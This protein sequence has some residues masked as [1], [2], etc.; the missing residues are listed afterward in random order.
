[1]ALTFSSVRLAI[2]PTSVPCPPAGGTFAVTVTVTGRATTPG[3][4]DVEVKDVGA[5][6]D[7]LDQLQNVIVTGGS[8]L[9]TNTHNFTL[10]CDDICEI[11]GPSGSSGNQ[12]CTD[13]G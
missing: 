4:Y 9:F 11:A 12:T 13:T 3:S 1:M 10:T 7:L 6:I 2:N 8:Q 5:G